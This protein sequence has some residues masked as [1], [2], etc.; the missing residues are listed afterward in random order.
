MLDSEIPQWAIYLWKIFN[1]LSRPPSMGGLSKISQQEIV[2]YQ[3]NHNIALNSFELELIE[4]ID[5]IALDVFN[6]EKKDK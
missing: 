4:M 3:S 1:S 2:A 6:K 5:N